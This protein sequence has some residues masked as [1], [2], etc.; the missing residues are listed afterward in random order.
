MSNPQLIKYIQDALAN[1]I[2]IEQ[3]KENLLVGGWKENDIIL[4]LQETNFI[5]ETTDIIKLVG[6]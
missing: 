3:I 2:S 6:W 5:K 1:N 4:A